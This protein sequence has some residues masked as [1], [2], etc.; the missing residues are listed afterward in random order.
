MMVTM[1]DL[2]DNSTPRKFLRFEDFGTTW[3]PL[4]LLILRHCV[5]VWSAVLGEIMSKL[6]LYPCAR[7]RICRCLRAFVLAGFCIGSVNVIT[8]RF[9]I[10]ST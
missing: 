3:Y 8:S 5:T 4:L 7:A 2:G 6:G 9:Q 1:D 10:L